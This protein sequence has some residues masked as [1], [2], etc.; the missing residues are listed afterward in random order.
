MDTYPT[1]KQR[2]SLERIKAAIEEHG[3][4]PGHY[5]DGHPEKVTVDGVEWNAKEL[6]VHCTSRKDGKSFPS[7]A[8]WVWDKDR[9]YVYVSENVDDISIG[10]QH[11]WSLVI[12]MAE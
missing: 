4:L 8:N 1:D 12:A 11:S 7:R 5:R 6:T 3:P 10:A 9:P 2:A